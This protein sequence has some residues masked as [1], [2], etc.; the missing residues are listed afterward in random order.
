MHGKHPEERAK[1][2]DQEHYSCG[3]GGVIPDPLTMTLNDKR[4]KTFSN[5]LTKMRNKE[6]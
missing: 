1:I 5:D 4:L 6:F 2:L 3:I